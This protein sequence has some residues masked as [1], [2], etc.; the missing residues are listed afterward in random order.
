MTT[1]PTGDVEN[2]ALKPCPFCGYVPP[3]V[4]ADLGELGH[5]CFSGR[6]L[7]GRWNHRPLEDSLTKAL[8]EARGEVEELRQFVSDIEYVFSNVWA[9]DRKAFEAEFLPRARKLI[10]KAALSPEKDQK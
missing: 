4:R 1:P 3:M 10:S 8:S 5:S 2:V 9:L 7:F 6:I